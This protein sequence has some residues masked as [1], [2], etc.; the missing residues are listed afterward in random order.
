MG[1]EAKAANAGPCW[2]LRSTD[3]IDHRWA[4]EVRRTREGQRVKTQKN[5]DPN[6]L[7]PVRDKS[8]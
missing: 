4:E 6:R 3:T 5:R 1:P 8:A 2:G 7:E